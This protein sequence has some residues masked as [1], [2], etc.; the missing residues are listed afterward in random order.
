[1]VVFV[2]AQNRMPTNAPEPMVTDEAALTATSGN[3]I[4]VSG[5]S[6]AMRA[7]ERLIADIA[8]TDIPV[9]LMGESGTGKEVVAL[10]IHR[11]SR[12]RKEPFVKIGCAALTAESFDWRLQATEKSEAADRSSGVRTLFLDEISELD[13][14]C[15]A[16]L[17][18]ALP[19]G[20]AAQQHCL[21]ARVI[22]AT[23]RNL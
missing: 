15:Q 13:A 11:L 8:P 17:L 21:E 6:P 4:F 23:S 22:C 20:E 18:H 3:H 2:Q 7:I 14:A 19:D 10:Q 9:L 5:V 12:G 16:K 1:M